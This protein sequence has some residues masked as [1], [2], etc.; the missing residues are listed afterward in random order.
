MPDKPKRH[1]GVEAFHWRD[2]GMRQGEAI[3][4]GP[5]PFAAELH[6]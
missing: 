3:E 4:E 5:H 2:D 6:W 1:G